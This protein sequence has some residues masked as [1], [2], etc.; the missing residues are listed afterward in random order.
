VGQDRHDERQHQRLVHRLLARGP[1]RLHRRVDGPTT[2]SAAPA[3]LT[4]SAAAWRTSTAS[5][6]STAAPCRRRST[7]ARGSSSRGR[8]PPRRPRRPDRMRRRPPGRPGAARQAGA[9]RASCGRRRRTWPQAPGAVPPQRLHEQAEVLALCN[10]RAARAPPSVRQEVPRERP[11]R[12]PERPRPCGRRAV[13][14]H[15]GLPVRHG[16]DDLAEVDAQVDAAAAALLGSGCAPVTRGPSACR[17]CS[18][19]RS[20]T[21]GSCAPGS[22]RCR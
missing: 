4:R 10:T 14:G 2:T 6:R 8:G 7:T 15:D 3:G 13:P 1:R 5:S 18:S 12:Q 21:S 19:S 17:T 16:L 20:P 9:G 11:R 22:S